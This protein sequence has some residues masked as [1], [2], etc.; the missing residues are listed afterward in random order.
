MY[1][2]HITMI[3]NPEI[4]EGMV[5][6]TGWHFSKIDGDPLLGSGVKCYA[7][8]NI[9]KDHITL[10]SCIT[11]MNSVAI[12]LSKQGISVIRQKIEDIVYDTKR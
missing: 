7:T 9:D 11:L 1:E 3:G 8:T 4:I 12:H 5:K 10:E 2:C 6:D